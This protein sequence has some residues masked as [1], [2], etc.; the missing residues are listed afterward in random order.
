MKRRI[1]SPALTARVYEIMDRAVEEG[2]V[3]GWQRA[4]KHTD[5]PHAETLKDEIADAVMNSICEVFDFYDG[6]DQ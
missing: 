4:H 1:G 5:T 3:S 6:E 2:V